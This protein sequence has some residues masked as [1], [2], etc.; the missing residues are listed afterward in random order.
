MG[1]LFSALRR[2]F[3]DGTESP[4]RRG[5]AFVRAAQRRSAAKQ[6]RTATRRKQRTPSPVRAAASRSATKRQRTADKE[7]SVWAEKKR[8]QAAWAAAQAEVKKTRSV[9][10]AVSKSQSLLPRYPMQ[11]LEVRP[12]AAKSG[13]VSSYINH[14]HLNLLGLPTGTVRVRRG[15]TPKPRSVPKTVSANKKQLVIQ[16]DAPARTAK[17]QKLQVVREN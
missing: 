5:P 15:A 8:A 4:V 6:Q 1:A 3:F 14:P 10:K 12:K 17:T 2:M 9:R 11:G 7:N 16:V 13:S